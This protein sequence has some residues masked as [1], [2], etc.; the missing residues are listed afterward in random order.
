MN[1]MNKNL[2]TRLFVLLYFFIQVL[3][4]NIGCL[5]CSITVAVNCIVGKNWLV[6]QTI[7]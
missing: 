1:N 5:F 4:I 7:K 6:H 3:N 2:E